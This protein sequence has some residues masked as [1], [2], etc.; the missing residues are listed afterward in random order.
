[1]DDG[2]S[3]VRTGCA[4]AR[5]GGRPTKRPKAKYPWAKRH[6]SGRSLTARALLFGPLLMAPALLAGCDTPSWPPRGQA[7]SDQQASSAASDGPAPAQ[8]HAVTQPQS[9]AASLAQPVP[10]QPQAIQVQPSQQAAVSQPVAPT[11]ASP[12]ATE[13]GTGDKPVSQFIAPQGLLTQPSGPATP[14]P[15][16]QEQSAQLMALARRVAQARSGVASLQETE[17]QTAGAPPALPGDSWAPQATIAGAPGQPT[18]ELLAAPDPNQAA[19]VSGETLLITR[20]RQAA[21]PLEAATTQPGVAQPSLIQPTGESPAPAVASSSPAPTLTP[22]TLT[23]PSGAAPALLPATTGSP[24]PADPG[25]AELAAAPPDPSVTAATTTAPS[26]ASG[27]SESSWYQPWTWFGDSDESQEPQAETPAAAQGELV[28]AAQAE[29]GIAPPVA[30]AATA[31]AQAGDPDLAA[32]RQRIL[33]RV[34]AIQSGERLPESAEPQP[35]EPSGP[36]VWQAQPAEQPQEM[37][38]LTVQPEIT[39]ATVDSAQSSPGLQALQ[40]AQV[41]AESAA[42]A[43]ERSQR[44]EIR[45]GEALIDAQAAAQAA[46]TAAEAA[47]ELAD[48]AEDS[49][50][51]QRA[52]DLVLE[53]NQ[54]AFESESQARRARDAAGRAEIAMQES[55]RAAG[56]AETQQVAAE[57]ATRL[58]ERIADSLEDA[59]SQAAAVQAEQAGE[60]A[61]S[62]AERAADEAQA[63]TPVPAPARTA[64][65][66]S[67]GSP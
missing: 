37:A 21:E 34:R 2:D 12:L 40:R 49:G 11:P 50:P 63:G 51:G 47:E 45:A 33:E 3:R 5:H 39:G 17:P 10:Q 48:Q 13:D 44:A 6:R 14:G 15:T 32:S 64:W 46:E 43:R 24:N 52:L 60:A 27:E 66:A 56:E 18:G 31:A 1:M 20:A 57:T 59:E 22:P 8:P 38:A 4:D 26:E 16:T 19:P 23:P 53:S 28:P 67:S 7:L 55:L 42:A 29:A 61:E 30:A 41:A 25:S 35:E 9:T 65:T 62:E 54:R 58:A 36:G